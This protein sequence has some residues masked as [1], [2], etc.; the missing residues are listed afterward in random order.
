MTYP[1]LETER[2]F[3]RILNLTHTEEIYKHFSDENVT[4]YMDIEPCKDLNEA[5]ELIKY[6]QDDAGC[7]WGMFDKETNRLIGTCGFHYIRDTENGKIAEIGYDLAHSH[8]GKGLMSE[9]LEKMI[10]FGFNEKCFY[11]IDA[12]V[13]PRNERSL[14]VLN[15]LGFSR[16][17]ELKDN[18][19]YFYKQRAYFN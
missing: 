9:V 13:E 3:L 10:E 5:E 4:K 2:V 7:R 6:H 14:N 18:L 15:R 1:S 17:R 11:M 8:W 19:V 16:N 12:T